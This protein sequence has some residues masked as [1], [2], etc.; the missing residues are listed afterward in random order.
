MTVSD[1]DIRA[2]VLAFQQGS[3]PPAISRMIYVPTSE[4]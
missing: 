1:L 3:E 4:S 2:K